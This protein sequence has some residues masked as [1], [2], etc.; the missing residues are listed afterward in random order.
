MA[1]WVAG[2][3]ALAG[4]VGILEHGYAMYGGGQGHKGMARAFPA[5]IPF[6]IVSVCY[7][8]CGW[9]EYSELDQLRGL[10]GRREEGLVRLVFGEVRPGHLRWQWEKVMS[11]LFTMSVI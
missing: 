2:P 5:A 8:L 1:Q 10:G 7:A 9:Q 6:A 3:I 4:S 11:A